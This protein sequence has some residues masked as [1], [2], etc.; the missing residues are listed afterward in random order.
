MSKEAEQP[1]QQIEQQAFHA[2]REWPLWL[3]LRQRELA[4]QVGNNLS[5][6]PGTESQA[7]SSE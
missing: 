5:K 1:W 4:Q 3:L 2:F 7:K 6:Q